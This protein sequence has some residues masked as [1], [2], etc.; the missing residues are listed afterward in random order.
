MLFVTKRFKMVK[1]KC[2]RVFE[3][4]AAPPPGHMADA[5][6]HPYFVIFLLSFSWQYFHDDDTGFHCEMLKSY[7]RHI[8][9]VE[10]SEQFHIA[11][12]KFRLLGSFELDPHL[13]FPRRK[14]YFQTMWI[15]FYID[16][17]LF[18]PWW[19]SKKSIIFLLSICDSKPCFEP[20]NNRCS[21]NNYW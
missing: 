11:W 3:P 20:H 9:L 15:N 10:C 6:F 19:S 12:K 13:I 4:H 21:D 1:P 5:H 2:R 14:Q 7:W 17:C 16:N 18:H 8:I